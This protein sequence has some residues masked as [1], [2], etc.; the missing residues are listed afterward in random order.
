MQRS[1]EFPLFFQTA[2]A[3]FGFLF[4]I[5]IVSSVSVPKTQFSN[6]VGTTLEVAKN[7]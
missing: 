1:S 6:T 2:I 4:L 5:A 3:L 7:L